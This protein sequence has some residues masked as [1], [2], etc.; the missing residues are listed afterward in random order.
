MTDKLPVP[1][2]RL[3]FR[4]FFLAGSVFSFVA[5]LAWLLFL[6][7]KLTL[8]PYG[9]AIFWHSH[10]MLF[11]FVSA[12]VVGFLLTAV[13]TWTSTPS[14]KG[15]PLAALTA[16]WLAARVGALF[17]WSQ[18]ELY[19]LLDLAFLPCAAFFLGRPIFRIRQY[20]NMF[21]VPVL[22]LMTLANGLMHAGV[23]HH[24]PIWI[25]QGANLCVWLVVFIMSVLGGRV[26]PMFTANGT[27]TP[28]AEPIH[29][30]E[31]LTLGT[32]LLL[33]LVHGLNFQQQLPPLLMATLF[34]IAGVAHGLRWLRWR[35]WVGLR[36]PL[37]WS[38]HTAYCFIPLGLLAAAF[39]HTMGIAI[40]PSTLLHFFTAGA[41]GSLIIAMMSR[42]S[43]GHSGRPLS[44]AK[45]MTPCFAAIFL[46][47][48]CRSLMVVLLPQWH[49]LWLN[50]SSALWLGAFTGFIWVYTPILTRPRIDGK[51]G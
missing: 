37:V 40:S 32:T 24:N 48:L 31:K 41:M 16:L 7:G 23:I 3:A 26:I 45:L 29:A 13:Q 30:L 38:L 8:S 10:E 21:F 1:V 39:S 5:I 12:I 11:G 17:N 49:E 9:G 33:A 42:V 46:A 28:K 20:R 19:A 43:L 6:N 27:R 36:A 44:P 35:F 14:I 51:P 47:G 22:L 4:S 18:P 2:F 25:S 15:V 50:L 34:G